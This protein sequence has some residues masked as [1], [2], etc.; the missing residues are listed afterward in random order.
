MRYTSQVIARDYDV[1]RSY[2]KMAALHTYAIVTELVPK[3]SLS[4][5]ILLPVDFL[6]AIHQVHSA[7]SENQESSSTQHR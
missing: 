7:S 3:V 4:Q 6:K 5:A 2:A 1:M